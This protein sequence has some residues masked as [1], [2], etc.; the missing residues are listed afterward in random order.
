MLFEDVPIQ[1]MTSEEALAWARKH[2]GGYSEYR[3]AMADFNDTRK[4]LV[5]CEIERALEKR[6]C[7]IE[8]LFAENRDLYERYREAT[9]IKI[10]L[11]SKD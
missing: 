1:K 10:G 4:W 8:E 11:R 9:S 6:N 3:R 5:D 7:S 2:Y